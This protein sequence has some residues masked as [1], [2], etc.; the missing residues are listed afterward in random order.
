[1]QA[2]GAVQPTLRAL[3]PRGIAMGEWQLVSGAAIQTQTG[4]R[5]TVGRFLSGRLHARSRR[6]LPFCHSDIKTP[7]R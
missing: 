3:L 7:W 1:M 6:E 2:T 4:E 5:L